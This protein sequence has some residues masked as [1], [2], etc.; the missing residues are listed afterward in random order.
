[1]SGLYNKFNTQFGSLE[2]FKFTRS[3]DLFLI[4]DKEVYHFGASLKDLG[5]KWLAFS[6]LHLELD[7]ILS[8]LKRF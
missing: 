2:I 3:H 4:I 1:M 7:L 5:K 6:K 8:R